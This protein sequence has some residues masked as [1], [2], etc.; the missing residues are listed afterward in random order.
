MPDISM[1]N[2]EL[3]PKRESCY[4]STATPSEYMQSYFC[5]APFEIIDGEWKCDYYWDNE[6]YKKKT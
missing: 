2:T 3:C 5:E 1:C 4:R 6:E